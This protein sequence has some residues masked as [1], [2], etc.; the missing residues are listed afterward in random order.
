MTDLIE[1]TNKELAEE[2]DIAHEILDSSDNMSSKLSEVGR[3]IV[4][5]IIAGAWTL[6]YSY[7]TF[8]PS[9]LIICSIALAFLYLFCD[10]LY[11]LFMK[12]KYFNYTYFDN[13]KSL[14]LLKNIT[15]KDAD[16]SEE[17]SMPEWKRKLKA[18]VNSQAKL[19]IR[20]VWWVVFKTLILLASS[21]LIIIHVLTV[22][23][24]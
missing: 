3:Q 24:Y 17:E 2:Q 1:N 18:I 10:L 20:S 11:L 6:S 4:F 16:C 13:E 9:N 15:K 19:K 14:L 8:S 21:L 7:N 23:N 12:I 22:N 5:A